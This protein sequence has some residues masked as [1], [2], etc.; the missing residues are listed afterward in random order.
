M[1]EE[2]LVFPKL[3]NNVWVVAPLFSFEYY[4]AFLIHATQKLKCSHNRLVLWCLTLQII[5]LADS[6]L[7]LMPSAQCL[8]RLP[9]NCWG[10]LILPKGAYKLYMKKGKKEDNVIDI[11]AFKPL[12]SMLVKIQLFLLG[13]TNCFYTGEGKQ[14][15]I[16]HDCNHMNMS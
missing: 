4:W 11:L 2:F 13:S 9:I 6:H 10:V 1:F 3:Y 15:V 7:S 14:L 5:I 12:W 8:T 16:I